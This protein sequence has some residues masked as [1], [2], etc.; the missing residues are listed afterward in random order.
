MWDSLFGEWVVDKDKTLKKVS[1]IVPFCW[2]E[3]NEARG[4]IVQ[5]LMTFFV[6]AVRFEETLLADSMCS[7]D[8]SHPAPSQDPFTQVPVAASARVPCQ[9]LCS[10]DEIAQRIAKMM[11]LKY[12]MHI[13]FFGK[14]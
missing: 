14:N 2:F 12:K 11:F 4:V 9:S 8:A 5:S 6:P 7:T 3:D 13:S 1:K 10:T